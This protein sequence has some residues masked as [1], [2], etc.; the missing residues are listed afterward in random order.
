ML[1]NMPVCAS[2]ASWPST[3]AAVV[4]SH[5]EPEDERPWPSWLTWT[6]V[7]V[8]AGAATGLV[9]WQA[10]AFERSE[11]GTEFVF[12]GPDAAGFAF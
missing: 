3:S 7:G 9:L 10:G 5:S 11:P 2:T 6:L 1:E 4:A 8:G 12:T